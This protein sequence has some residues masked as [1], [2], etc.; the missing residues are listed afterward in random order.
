M[1][2][3]IKQNKLISDISL[4]GRSI[5]EMQRVTK[6][7]WKKYNGWYE[8]DENVRR[9]GKSMAGISESFPTSP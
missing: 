9:N 5:A 3:E 2:A 6:K 4:L 8:N 7:V 1:I